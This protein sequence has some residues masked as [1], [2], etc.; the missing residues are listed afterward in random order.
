[1]SEPVGVVI[2]GQIHRLQDAVL[3]AARVGCR[4]YLLRRAAG[5]VIAVIGAPYEV[6]V[7]SV[8]EGLQMI[9]DEGLTLFAVP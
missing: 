8:P 2:D 9:E 4:Y 5:D 1:M 6:R 7:V 3:L